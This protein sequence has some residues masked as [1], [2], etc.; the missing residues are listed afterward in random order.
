MKKL[1][2]LTLIIALQ[3]GLFPPSFAL[4]EN[5]NDK[6]IVS[7]QKTKKE[8]RFFNKKTNI[9]SNSKDLN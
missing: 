5:S 6:T 2:A 1:T 3:I 4:D 7:A 9:S 8:G